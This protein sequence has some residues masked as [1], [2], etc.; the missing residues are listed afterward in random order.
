MNG[1]KNT[2]MSQNNVNRRQFF[3]R[4]IVGAAAFGVGTNIITDKKAASQ[5]TSPNSNTRAL[6]LRGGDVPNI[7][8]IMADQ[9]RWDYIECAEAS[10]V[11]TPNIDALAQNGVRFSNATCNSP[12]C[13]P[14]RASLIS[15]LYP[16]RNGVIHNKIVYPINHIPTY[17]QEL[18]NNGYR[19]GCVGKIELHKP[20]HFNGKNGNLPVMYQAGFTDPNNT[21][22]KL[23]IR[24]FHGPYGHY[25]A[26]KGLHE[27]LRYD[28]WDIRRQAVP[29]YAEDSV[30]T[31]EDYED[32]WIG[33]YACNWLSDVSEESP[34]HYFVS[35]VVPHDPWD[36]PVNYAKKYRNAD[37]PL[38]IQDTLINKPS[39]QKRNQHTEGATPEQMIKVQQ[40]YCA[41]IELIDN[42]IGK[43]INVLKQR[44]MY[45]NTLI[46]FCSDHGEKMGDHGMFYKSVPYDS[47]VK[48]PL[49]MR[50][51]GVSNRGVDD[52]LV[53]LFDLYPTFLETAGIK[54]P[55]NIDAHSLMPILSG[56]KRKIRDYQFHE[57]Y[58]EDY[59]YQMVCDKRYKY[60]NNNYD[61][62]EL[63]D[64]EEDVHE[65]NNLIDKYPDLRNRLSSALTEMSM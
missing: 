50:G 16:H 11:H 63:Y 22:D 42:Y 41:M 38:P 32:A 24:E 7:L 30:L 55:S 18:R 51:P 35:F 44:N 26:E 8:M 43:I 33:R 6:N 65:L 48:I 37:V 45:E 29:F 53:Q 49:I 9:W 58:Y 10:F 14:S 27:K 13:A 19:V 62:N 20:I 28:Y 25:L 61:I 39:Y 2:E 60:V 34:W 54:I 47:S 4:S 56:K 12:I 15:G 64:R 36:P 17:Y 5:V 40:Q 21:E 3:K 1:K 31:E 59:N 52:A 23:D 57:L 46:V